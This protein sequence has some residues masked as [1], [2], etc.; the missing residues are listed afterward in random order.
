M[1]LSLLLSSLRFDFCSQGF[2]LEFF[3]LRLGF[4]LVV[5]RFHFW[6]DPLFFGEK[7]RILFSLLL[8][9]FLRLMRREGWRNIGRTHHLVESGFR[10]SLERVLSGSDFERRRVL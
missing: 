8:F 7:L 3:L 1:L 6:H 9:S 4:Q 2:G 10:F 5:L